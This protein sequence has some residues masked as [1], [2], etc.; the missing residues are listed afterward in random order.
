MST[1]RLTVTANAQT[2][3]NIFRGQKVPPPLAMP[4]GVLA[5]LRPR[6]FPQDPGHAHCRLG[7]LARDERIDFLPLEYSLK[8]LGKYEYSTD[9]GFTTG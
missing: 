8:Y 1:E 4:A 2:L 3:Y 9:T 6:I 5:L 7:I